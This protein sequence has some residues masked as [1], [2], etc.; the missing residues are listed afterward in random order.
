MASRTCKYEPCG[1]PL[2]V[3]AREDAKFCDELCRSRDKNE[4]RRQSASDTRVNGASAGVGSRGGNIRTLDQ[5]RDVQAT[6]KAKRDWA[7]AIDEQIRST[8]LNTGHFHADDLDAL[9]VPPE[10]AN[11]KGLR[12]GSFSRR[13][14]MEGTGE[15]RKVSH[16][17]A[18]ARKA[19]VYR[20][21]EKGREDL[22]KPDDDPNPSGLCMCG[23]GQAT[24]IST[25]T[26]RQR[27]AVRGKHFR[28]VAGHQRRSAPE[29]YIVFDHDQPRAA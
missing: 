16:A 25:E 11:T 17:A 2:P 6:V 18:N 23:C 5:A 8:L 3:T 1:K 15:L 14:L 28:Y 21:T 13:K 20:L 27:G 10:H 12:I 22:S 19:P 9:E 26:H 7:G 4:R 24:A 29:Q